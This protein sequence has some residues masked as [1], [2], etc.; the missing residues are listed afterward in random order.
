[1]C[2]VMAAV[3]LA[4]GCATVWCSYSVFPIRVGLGKYLPKYKNQQRGG[5]ELHILRNGLTNFQLGNC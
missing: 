2:S 3:A 1:M 5:L 4:N